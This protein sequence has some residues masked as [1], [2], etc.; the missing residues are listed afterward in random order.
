MIQDLI[1]YS[2][3]RITAHPIHKRSVCNQLPVLLMIALVRRQQLFIAL[4]TT[5]LLLPATPTHQHPPARGGL[6]RY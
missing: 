3:I 2:M 1:S 6:K 5:Y 4:D